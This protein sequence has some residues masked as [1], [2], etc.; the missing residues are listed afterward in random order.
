[1]SIETVKICHPKREWVIINKSDFDPKKHTLY[2]V[3]KEE[4]VKKAGKPAAK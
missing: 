2:G 4:P 3:K 1:M